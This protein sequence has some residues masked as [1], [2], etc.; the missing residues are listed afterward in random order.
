MRLVSAHDP[1]ESSVGRGGRCGAL[2]VTMNPISGEGQRMI[3]DQTSRHT[4]LN[5]IALAG[6]LI[7]PVGL[8]A[9]V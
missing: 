5:L 3:A 4:C 6:A 8:N 2:A 1:R 7:V 9:I